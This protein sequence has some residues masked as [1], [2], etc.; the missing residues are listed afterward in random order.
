MAPLLVKAGHSSIAQGQ[1]RASTQ[2]TKAKMCPARPSSARPCQS[3]MPGVN[4][5]AALH[6]CR[7]QR[8]QQS[9]DMQL[10]CN[11][12]RLAQIS[13]QVSSTQDSS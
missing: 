3:R 11:V 7:G 5:A 1:H 4:V 2:P 10:I 13:Q 9:P 6:L 8:T 12:P